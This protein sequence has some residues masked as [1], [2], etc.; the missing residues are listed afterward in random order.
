MSSLPLVWFLTK[1]SKYAYYS[2]L[3]NAYQFHLYFINIYL[4]EYLALLIHILWISVHTHTEIVSLVTQKNFF[5]WWASV[6]FFWTG[7]MSESGEVLKTA[8]K[9]WIFFFIA[10]RL[11]RKGEKLF[12]LSF[13]MPLPTL[14]LLNSNTFHKDNLIVFRRI[15]S[16]KP[17]QPWIKMLPYSQPSSSGIFTSAIFLCKG[18]GRSIGSIF[19]SLRR[20]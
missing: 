2:L 3:G 10:Y 4:A 13:I 19:C 16:K 14:S 9:P 8:C 12:L 17:Q 18:V 1:K 11:S 6:V 5:S 20:E 15:S 7:R